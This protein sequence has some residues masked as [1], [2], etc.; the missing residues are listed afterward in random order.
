MPISRIR[1]KR[2][3][4]P[5]GTDMPKPVKVGSPRWL[6]PLFLT[7]MLVGLAW[8]VVYYITQARYPIGDLGNWNMAIG[9]GFILVGFGLATRWE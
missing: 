9:F 8:L 2:S 3:Y 4:V 5:P 6:V 7:L 1:R